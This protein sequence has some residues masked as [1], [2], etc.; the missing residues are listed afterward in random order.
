MDLKRFLWFLSLEDLYLIAEETKAD[1]GED[2]VLVHGAHISYC[3]LDVVAEPLDDALTEVNYHLDDVLALYLGVAH[4]HCAS[5]G[6][7][8][9]GVE[10]NE[11]LV[12]EGA[13]LKG[14][15]AFA[16]ANP[17]Q[18]PVVLDDIDLETQLADSLWQGITS[19]FVVILHIFEVLECPLVEPVQLLASSLQAHLRQEL[20]IPHLDL[21]LEHVRYVIHINPHFGEVVLFY[22][23][24]DTRNL[25]AD[26]SRNGLKICP[27]CDLIAMDGLL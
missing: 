26:F 2:L 18:K 1:H 6:H 12:V 9:A 22:P 11:V 25:L 27:L 8:S 5:V 21:Q 13:V 20:M 23:L 14:V 10:R 17:K 24:L 3:H 4:V 19:Y 7:V 15:S 16:V